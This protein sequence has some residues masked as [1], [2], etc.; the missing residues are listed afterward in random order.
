MFNKRKVKR[1]IDYFRRINL[2]AFQLVGLKKTN[3]YQTLSPYRDYQA[4]IRY[5]SRSYIVLR[6]SQLYDC[7]ENVY[8]QLNQVYIWGDH[9]NLRMCVSIRWLQ[10]KGLFKFLYKLNVCSIFNQFLQF[11]CTFLKILNIYLNIS[12]RLP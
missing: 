1:Y 4:V 10:I 8:L 2:P 9:T 5:S 12:E 11:F 3:D 7:F 6:P